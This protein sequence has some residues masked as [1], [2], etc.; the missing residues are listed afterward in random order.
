MRLLYEELTFV[1][2]GYIYEVSN[3]LGVGYD[4]HSY[5]LALEEKLRENNIP[6]KSQ[7]HGYVCH[8]GVKA[9]EFIADLIVDDVIILE[10]KNIET[11]FHPNH[12]F[13]LLSYLKHWK[14]QLGL[15]VNF[16]LPKAK[17]QRVPFT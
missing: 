17:I 12:V 4:E 6:F 2:R 14:K 11:G 15:L 16:G 7:V 9:Q 3:E 8:K 10:L 5:Q 13:Q 1:V